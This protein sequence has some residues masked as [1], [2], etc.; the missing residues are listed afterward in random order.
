MKSLQEENSNL[1]RLIAPSS[2]NSE[3]SLGVSVIFDY[4]SVFKGTI[5]LGS[6]FPSSRGRDGTKRT[7]Q[8]DCKGMTFFLPIWFIILVRT[9]TRSLLCVKVESRYLCKSGRVH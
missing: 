1:R 3:D 5:F 9:I 2:L 4:V 8:Q 7:K 6:L